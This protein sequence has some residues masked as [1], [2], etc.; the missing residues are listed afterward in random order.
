MPTARQLSPK[1]LQR[2]YDE[3]WRDENHHQGDR[4]H[5]AHCHDETFNAETRFAVHIHPTF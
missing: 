1:F 4:D 2:N 3:R 5:P